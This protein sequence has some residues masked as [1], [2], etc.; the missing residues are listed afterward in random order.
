MN[1]DH[2]RFRA[3]FYARWEKEISFFEDDL[4]G[5]ELQIGDEVKVRVMKKDQRCKMITL[6]PET[7]VASP[8]VLEH[9]SRG[10][11]GCTGVYGA[12][13]SEGIVRAND[14]IYTI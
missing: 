14:P 10:H 5:R 3:N 7:A 6:D 4:V 13:L 2:R 1:L 9:V 8:T 12:V 11:G